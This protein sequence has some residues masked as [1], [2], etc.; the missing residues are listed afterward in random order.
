MSVD[1]I[2]FP[3]GAQLVDCI[4]I[5][6]RTF[7]DSGQFSGKNPTDIQRTFWRPQKRRRPEVRHSPRNYAAN[8]APFFNERAV[9]TLA[10]LPRA[11]RDV[12]PPAALSRPL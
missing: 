8:I 9:M 10:E 6:Q 12:L 2:K 3:K 1:R 11:I 5:I 4:G 7:F